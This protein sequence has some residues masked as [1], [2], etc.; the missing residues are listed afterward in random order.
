MNNLTKPKARNPEILV[1]EIG[2]EVLIYDLE[3]NKAFSL[4]ETCAMVWRECDGE[5]PIAEIASILNRR[6]N[7]K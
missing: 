5:K 6:R 7:I 2:D 4:N 3:I 1:Q